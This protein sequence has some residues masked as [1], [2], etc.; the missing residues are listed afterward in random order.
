MMLLLTTVMI[1]SCAHQPYGATNKVYKKQAK[2]YANVLKQQPATPVNGWIG[3]VNFN[4][5]KPNYVI[6]HHTAQG[7][8]DTTFRTFTLARTQ[9]SAHYVVCSDGSVHQML[10]DYLRAWHAGA[11]KWGNVTDMNSCSIG[12]ELDND[13]LSPFQPQQINSLLVLLDTLRQRYN[14]PAGSTT[15][16]MPISRLASGMYIMQVEIRPGEIRNFKFIKQ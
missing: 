16:N 6:I 3:T 9:V 1:Y 10:S 14:I 13:G 4:M 2:Q 7:S 15:I 8:C 12:I 5:R 11:S